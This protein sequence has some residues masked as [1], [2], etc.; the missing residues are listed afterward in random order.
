MEIGV[1]IVTFNRLEKL[2]IALQKFE[3]Q[4]K[5]PSYVIVVN[6]A[7]TD[8]TEEYLEQWAKKEN[9]FKRFAINMPSNTGGSGGFYT[10]IDYAMQLNSDWIW[11]SD[12]DAYPENDAIKQASDF[13]DMQMDLDDISAICGKVIKNG[14]LDITH[15]KT[16]LKKG[17]RIC[18]VILPEENYARETFTKNTFTYVGTIMNKKKLAQAGL[19]NKEYFIYWDDLEHG[20][21]MSKIGKIICVPAISVHH[22]VG[23][24]DEGINWKLYYSYR[25][26]VDTY[27]IHFHGICYYYFCLK[28]WIKIIVNILLGRKNIKINIL[29]EAFKDARHQYFGMHSLYKPGWKVS[30]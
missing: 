28:V 9:G 10:G 18:E 30:E 23:K 5:A 24:E 26:M 22:D 13:L 8:G 2:K 3:E 7:S 19:P 21:R 16:Y 29:Q 14:E 17:I 12:D 1:V 6:N 27:H 11:V 25:N 4:I 20:L 15:G